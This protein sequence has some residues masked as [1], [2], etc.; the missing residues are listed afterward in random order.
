MVPDTAMTSTD[1]N[2]ANAV[3]LALQLSEAEASLAAVK[4]TVH[5]QQEQISLQNE[6]R[7]LHATQLG[8]LRVSDIHSSA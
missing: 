5:A 3:L 6:E 1:D 7:E 2:S 8:M 4:L